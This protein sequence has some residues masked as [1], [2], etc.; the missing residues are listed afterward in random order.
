[1]SAC[2]HVKLVFKLPSFGS[3]TLALFKRKQ[4]QRGVNVTES[5]NTFWNVKNKLTFVSIEKCS[6]AHER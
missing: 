4:D 3:H 2:V 6:L 5:L 1:M